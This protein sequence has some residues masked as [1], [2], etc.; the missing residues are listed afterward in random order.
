MKKLTLTMFAAAMLTLASCNEAARLAEKVEGTWSSAPVALANDASGQS[1]TTETF[2]FSREQATP[3]GTVTIQSA[4]SQMRP[5]SQANAFGPFAINVSAVASVQG[6]W[7]AIDDDEVKVSLDMNT[8]EV[9][10]DPN[11]VDLKVNP[12]SGA[13]YP[14]VDSIKPQVVSF[15]TA[16]LT[17]TM[18]THYARYNGIIDTDFKD[19][20]QSVELEIGKLEILLHKQ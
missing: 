13:E 18:T 12:L 15:L 11:T 3:G 7:E 9:N 20:G 14:Q 8:L 4:I 16:E 1:T 19:K 17:G 5:A 6:T 2:M 10:V